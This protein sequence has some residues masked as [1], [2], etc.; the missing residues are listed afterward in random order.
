MN[1]TLEHGASRLR[2][3]AQLGQQLW[4]DNLSRELLVSGQLADLIARDGVQGL[5]SNPAIFYQAIQHDPAYQAALPLLRTAH[6][7]PEARFEALVIPDVQ[8]A[9]DLFAPL[10]R[11]ADGK[12]GFVSFEVSPRLAHD[13]AATVADAKRLWALI[14]RPNAMIKIP[15]TPAGIAA[16]EEVIYAGINVNM[17]LIFS[18]SQIQAVRAAHRRGLARRLQDKLSVQR[19]ASVAS[20]F[21]SRIDVAVDAL[22][23]AADP[24][25]GQA[26]MAAARI[27]YADWKQ[28]SGFAV[29]AAF[30]ATPQWLLW[31]STA[32]KTTAERDVRY[33]EGLIGADTI[34]TVPDATLAAFRDHGVAA[35]AL[36]T[37]VQAERAVLAQLAHQGID[38]ETIGQQLLAAGLLQFEQ[39]FSKL[40]ALT[41]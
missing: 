6:A 3:V 11:D 21:I 9:C 26:A 2:A 38:L 41:E 32:T 8:R 15:A 27:A 39:A 34:N 13:A 19:I 35:A 24:L 4:L 40:L 16:L 22:L 23:P 30:G 37:E 20:V 17:T 1:N 33:V 28:D 14:A 36:G 7:S 5:T 18:A 25:R 10:Y 29:F 12:A 31:A